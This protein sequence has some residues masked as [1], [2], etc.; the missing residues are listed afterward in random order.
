MF[1]VT[2]C[3]SHGFGGSTAGCG[4]QVEPSV[5][6]A[7]TASISA[8]M[9]GAKGRKAPRAVMG[10]LLFYAAFPG[11]G[12]VP[13]APYRHFDLSWLRLEP[14]DP[15]DLAGPSDEDGA[16]DREALPPAAPP[17]CAPVPPV[18]SAPQA[19][20]LDDL[21]LGDLLDA[22]RPSR[23]PATRR[24]QGAQSS[25][26]QP[27]PRSDPTITIP[28]SDPAIEE[29]DPTPTP[30]AGTALRI[31]PPSAP[32]DTVTVTMRVTPPLEA[33]FP[34]TLD[35]GLARVGIGV[36]ET[37][38]AGRVERMNEAAERI[39]RRSLE[40]GPVALDDVLH[41][42][43]L[44]RPDGAGLDATPDATAWLVRDDGEPV[45]VR[46]AIVPRE[47]GG[48]TVLFRE[49]QT[50][51]V[52]APTVARRARY[53]PL[54]GLYSR[55]GIAERIEH[56]LAES[57]EPRVKPSPTDALHLSLTE[58]RHALVYIDLDRFSLVNSTCGHDAGDDL[59]QWVATRLY[60]VMDDADVAA[61]IAGD[62][63]AILL[64]DHDARD[65]ERK[66]RDVQRSLTEFRFAWGHK[67]FLVET[68]L[69]MFPFGADAGGPDAV[70]SAASHA[71]RIAKK[72]GGGRI[73]T[74]LE[75]DEDMVQ[76]R[77]SMEWVAGIQHHLAEGKIQLYAQTIHPI[78]GRKEQGGHFEV[79]MRVLDDKGRPTSPVGII[80]AAEN[81]RM[82]DAID[83]FVL[84]KAFQT[85]GALPRR[86]LR[87]LDLCSVNLSAISLA[88][89]GL[90]DFIVE[91]LE[92][93]SVPPGKICF[94]ITETTALN[95]LDEVRWLIQ[96]L[97]AMG[98]RFAI[99]DFGSGHAS[100]GYIE[101][102][103]VD[104]VKIDGMF[105]KD[106]MTNALHRAIVESVNRIATTLG[107]KTIAECVETAAAAEVL[108]GMG[109][110]YGQGWYYAR[111]VPIGDVCRA[112]DT[113]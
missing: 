74:Y 62:E 84:R 106:M 3:T 32:S 51:A 105:V 80:E 69:G 36:I 93:S 86:A 45:G 107:I 92:R 108:G 85:I 96:E 71:C 18:S 22:P 28:R 39:S 58:R 54:T 109:V 48:S 98:C 13:N 30:P 104:Y 41:T 72:N 33:P 8:A 89:E 24:E 68:S 99:D 75:G 76:S 50:G 6:K 52:F 91:H 110:H 46:H 111:P 83:R 44:P 88:R 14:Q 90:L 17:M 77:R 59:L 66:A 113:D 29:R 5:P 100:Y 101:R 26:R 78:G 31:P 61:R 65:A 102:L 63:F 25:Q 40:D 1:S 67:T 64:P 21:D 81:G 56:L 16:L 97:G 20:G 11:G 34:L 15:R 57:R 103:P 112:L 19:S 4:P 87:R 79:L 82:M 42:G 94:E 60:E 43:A 9:R 55:R 53:D 70:L 23:P 37:D 27:I 95:N 2:I 49:A 10:R 73:Q 35:A 38:A 47:G 7:V 12:Q